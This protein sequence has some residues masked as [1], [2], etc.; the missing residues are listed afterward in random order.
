MTSPEQHDARQGTGD[1]LTDP[2]AAGERSVSEPDADG[3]A[4]P[5]DD[6]RPEPGT[7]GTVRAV[8]ALSAARAPSSARPRAARAAGRRSSR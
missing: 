8:A 4:T 3:G 5:H 2:A 7:G 6:V 1:P